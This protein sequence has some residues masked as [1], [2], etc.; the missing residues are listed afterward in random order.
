MIETEANTITCRQDRSPAQIVEI[1]DRL[2]RFLT[3]QECWRL[4]GFTDQEYEA[5][6]SVNPT[7]GKMNRTLYEQAGNSMPVPVLESL[8]EA[9]GFANETMGFAK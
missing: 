6:M 3:E 5:A 1:A 8:F 4:M 9:L 7:K 2:Y